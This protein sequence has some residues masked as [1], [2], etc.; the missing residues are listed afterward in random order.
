MPKKYSI[1][2]EELN[3]IKSSANRLYNLIMISSDFAKNNSKNRFD[4]N[5]LISLIE[6]E[7]NMIDKIINLLIYFQIKE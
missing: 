7:L 4:G 6:C 1:T 5:C 3:E 2:D